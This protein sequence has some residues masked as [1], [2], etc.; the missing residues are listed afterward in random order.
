MPTARDGYREY[1]TE[2]LWDWLPAIYREQDAMEGPGMPNNALRAFIESLAEQAAVLKRDQDRLWDDAFVELADDWAIPYLAELLATRLVS[3]QNPRA[4]RIDVAKTVYYRRRKGTLP[5]LEQLIDDMTAW[6]GKVVEQ[7]R[8]LARTPHGLDGPARAGRI[9]ATPE[10][11][12]ADLRSVRGALLT[13]DPFCEFHFTPD[14][15][16]PGGLQANKLGQRGIGKLSVHVYRMQAAEFSGVQARRMVDVAGTMDAYTFDPSGRDVVL[17]SANEPKQNWTSTQWSAWRSAEEWR[18]PRAITCRL[19]GEA[20]YEVSAAAIAAV[21]NTGTIANL[22]DRQNSARDLQRLFGMRFVGTVAGSELLT[23]LL[24]GMPNAL[25]LQAA[26]PE[27]IVAALLDECGAVQLY[28]ASIRLGFQ[29]GTVIDRAVVRAGQLPNFAVPAATDL[30][31]VTAVID[32]Q[33]G[34]M[35]F[36]IGARDV[37]TVRSRYRVGM[38]GTFGAGGLEREIAVPAGAVLWQDGDTSAGIPAN[39]AVNVSDSSTFVNPPDGVALQASVIAAGEGQRPFVQVQADWVFT[40]AGDDRSLVLDGLWIG[41]AAGLA[42]APKVVLIGNFERVVLRY[43]TLDPGGLDAL[44]AMLQPV[45]LV[46]QG[47]VEELRIERCIVPSVRTEGAGGYIGRM[48]LNDSVIHAAA[49]ALTALSAPRAHLT[50]RRST[51]IGATMNA[52]ALD[53]E[54]LDASDSIVAGRA[55][56]TDAQTGCFRFSARGPG[57]MVPHPYESVELDGAPGSVS[58]AFASRRFGDA[59]YASLSPVAPQALLRGAEQGLEMGAFNNRALLIKQDS[60]RIKIDEYL[61]FG[62]LPNVISEN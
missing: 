53:V 39:G 31:G 33:R 37:D 16:R 56:V 12:L 62:R 52:L 11:A 29:D 45:A 59:D 43:C 13:D 25:F 50:M 10:G 61:P 18:L 7:F 17:F 24:G 48:V 44:G 8:R 27:I 5:V 35:L 14:V 57:S 36:D 4:R 51:V 1:F 6:D 47:F 21:I 9:T 22:S 15:R 40:A 34:R 26:L 23:R 46:V 54:W 60:L 20:I 38:L 28:P 3:V 32:P 2:K 49:P 41:A 58:R 55:D 19:L 42:S 30:S